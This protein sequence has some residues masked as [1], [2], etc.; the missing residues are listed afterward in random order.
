[1]NCHVYRVC[2]S[3]LYYLFQADAPKLRILHITD[4]HID[5]DYI[6]G[7]NS[8]CGEPICCRQGDGMARM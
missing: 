4:L 2:Q 6:P 5:N 3:S 8:D 7:S 1:M